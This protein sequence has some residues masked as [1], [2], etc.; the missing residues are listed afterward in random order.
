MILYQT[1]EKTELNTD[2]IPRGHIVMENSTITEE[3]F[4]NPN[5]FI[6]T[7]SESDTN[8]K[9][10]LNKVKAIPIVVTYKCDIILE[11][12]RD[13]MVCQERI[14]DSLWMNTLFGV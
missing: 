11:T 14:M 8:L 10:R 6:R 13:V 1:L 3:E 5:V 2:V 9:T 12:E 4:T 7:T